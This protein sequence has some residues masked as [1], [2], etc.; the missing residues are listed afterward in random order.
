MQVPS[1]DLAYW[2]L[3]L[4]GCLTIRNFIIHPEYRREGA[5]TDADI[6]GVRFPYRRELIRHPLPDDSWFVSYGNRLIL[7]IAEVKKGLC[8]LNGPWTDPHR[9]VVHKI[10]SAMGLFLEN[11]L[12]DVAG[13]LYR[14]G[15]YESSNTIVSLIAFGER[16]SSQL[17]SRY[18]HV[19]QLLWRQVLAFIYGR[20][21]TYENEKAWHEPWDE[22]GEKLYQSAVAVQSKTKFSQQIEIIP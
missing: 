13:E 1:E 8:A 15:C 3:R 6:V 20:F 7:V 5:S 17:S 12:D 16:Q 22:I 9:K 11:R 14:R 21:S 19:P 2:Y 4:N 10:L 18:P